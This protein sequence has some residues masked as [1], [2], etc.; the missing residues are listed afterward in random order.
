M[1]R[2]LLVLCALAIPGGFARPAPPPPPSPAVAEITL[3]ADAPDPPLPEPLPWVRA[4]APLRFV[5][6]RTG[7][8]IPVRLYAGDGS[9][10]EHVASAI[11]AVLADRRS[12]ESAPR[13][14]SDR[15]AAPH[16]LNRRVL[17]LVVKA[18]AHFGATE[19]RVVSSY[20]D[21][22][23]K[24]SRHRVGRALDFTLASVRPGK[25]ASYL[26]KL[27]R[28][29]VGIYT[30]PRTQFVHLDVRDESYHWA[31]GS[32]PGRWWRGSRMTDRAAVSRDAAY[33]PEDDW[34]GDA[35]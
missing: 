18:A 23:R 4:L 17:Q 3:V 28:V 10:D 32:P 35:H 21:G 2:S 8:A 6:T 29:G 16:R 15:D 33:R 12:S 31:D 5:N 20:R 22:G 14:S 9:V 27:A 13:T 26:R 24:G 30:H 25:L 11:D 7:A 1:R 19:V 34:P